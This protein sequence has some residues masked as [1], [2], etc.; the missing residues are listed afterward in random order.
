MKLKSP[1]N[2]K[3]REKN[4]NEKRL[5]KINRLLIAITNSNGLKLCILFTKRQQTEKKWAHVSLDVCQYVCA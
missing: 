5:C 1:R 2:G 4:D 3:E